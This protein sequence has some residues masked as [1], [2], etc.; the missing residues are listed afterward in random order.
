MSAG[1][2]PSLPKVQ[3]SDKEFSFAEALS[4][5]PQESFD[6]VTKEALGLPPSSKNIGT[7]T[8]TPISRTLEKPR[9]PEL[10]SASP[11]RPAKMSPIPKA[12]GHCLELCTKTNKLGD[13]V[14]VKILEY[15]TSVK[16][17][18]EG[19]DAL[20][21]GFLDTY[22]VLVLIQAGLK[23]FKADHQGLT[24]DDAA[25]LDKKLRV[26]HADVQLLDHLLTK[27][28][29]YER[30]GAMGRMRRGLGRMFGDADFERMSIAFA[31]TWKAL[32][33]SAT[34]FQ[35]VVGAQSVQRSLGIGHT[36]LSA[37][38]GR[39]DNKPMSRRDSVRSPSRQH[40]E[41]HAHPGTQYHPTSLQAHHEST[42]T[43]HEPASTHHQSAPTHHHDAVSHHHHDAVSHHHQ[44]PLASPP[45]PHQAHPAPLSLYSQI[46]SVESQPPL[47]PLPWTE[48]TTSFQSH[49]MPHSV[50]SPISQYP[51][52][53]LP[54]HPSATTDMS[55]LSHERM[56][57]GSAAAFDRASALDE[58]LSQATVSSAAADDLLEEIDGQQLG[59]KVVHLK[60][61]ATAMPRWAPR[62]PAPG[63][64]TGL[65]AT[66]RSAIR[67]KNH[68]LVEQLL[69]RG[70]F[71]SAVPDFHPLREAVSCSDSETLRLLLAF[72]ANPNEA[73]RDGTTPLLAAVQKSFLTGAVMLLKYG[74][75]PNAPAGPDQETPLFAS[76][77]AHKLG[78]THLLLIYGGDVKGTGSDGNT[79]LIASIGKRSPKKLVDLILDYAADP[80][81][82]NREGKTALFEAITCGRVEIV[83][84]LVSHGANPNLPGPKHMLWP[85]TYQSACLQV[86]LDS[87]ADFRKC[88]GI[89]ELATSINNIDS[90]R[91]LLA[92]GVDPNAKKDGVYTPLCTSIRDNRTDI[93]QLL[94][95][96]GAD[97]NVM[98]SEYPA[99]K[100]ITHNRLHFLPSLVSAGADMHTPKG[101]IET[102]VASNNTSAL[103]WL[104]D[105]GLDPNERNSKGQSPLTSAIRDNHLSMVDLLLTR[106]ADPNMRGQDWPVCLAVHNPPILSRVLSSLASPR[107][108]KGVMEMAVVADQLESIKLLLAAGVSVE[109]RNGGVFSPLTTA[110]RENRREIVTYLLTT[111]GA[112][113]NAPGEHLPIVKAVRRFRDGDVTMHKQLLAHGAD[114]NKMYRGWNAVMQAVEN[115]DLEVLKVLVERGVDLEAKDEM[116]RT[117]VQMASERGWDEA[118]SVLLGAGVMAL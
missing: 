46:G 107:A 101:I 7:V 5:A 39:L 87:G 11:P 109:D 18:P 53:G 103:E 97:P 65:K 30:K 8:V 15:L 68:T 13:L 6:L 74:A 36:G 25:E 93:F 52:S 3:R 66:L 72:G 42:S 2:A 90:V 49:D 102:A 89:M 70:L 77:S 35:D 45:L 116:G 111:G 91:I 81:D 41:E 14:S 78:L 100:C 86:L 115:G 44:T 69:D 60:A 64:A 84:S 38:L 95:S 75:D 26:A 21:H 99:F 117:V 61:D 29:D 85:A 23:Q 92:A 105:Q 73:D 27:L 94:L 51:P 37:A 1:I 34:V 50:A 114:P 118:V 22:E 96:N 82:K 57:L 106:G 98:A 67:S 12:Q 112:D 58:T 19:L 24:P 48:R 79:V 16:Q 56:A 28:L 108:F 88:P 20:A 55:T 9:T 62:T 76:A 113:V 32:K 110:I 104:L 80:N 59:S 54:R 4:L 63:D 17:L 71:P 40:Q 10:K 83:S 31:R 47:P 33:M 43:H